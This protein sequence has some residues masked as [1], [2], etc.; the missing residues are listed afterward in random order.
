MRRRSVVS[1]G[2]VVTVPGVVAA[3]LFASFKPDDRLD[4]HLAIH[5]DGV[6]W[7]HDSPYGPT[8]S[9]E[10]RKREQRNLIELVRDRGSAIAVLRTQRGLVVERVSSSDLDLERFV[11]LS[12]TELRPEDVPEGVLTAA[13]LSQHRADYGARGALAAPYT[14][15]GIDG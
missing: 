14:T 7:S 15:G 10:V 4:V 9:F 12:H 5:A 11:S 8:Q 3:M 2:V 13:E 6:G 1:L